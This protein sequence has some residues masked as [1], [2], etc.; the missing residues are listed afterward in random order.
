MTLGK[1]IP[2][3]VAKVESPLNTGEIKVTEPPPCWLQML[4]P[5]FPKAI[6]FIIVKS[7]PHK[8]QPFDP[9]RQAVNVE[10]FP[11]SAAAP[12]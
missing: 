8:F 5:K 1:F 2:F 7:P 12:P 4:D 9:L 10:I 6:K 11:V 3:A